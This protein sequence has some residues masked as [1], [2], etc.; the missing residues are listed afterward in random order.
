M[1]VGF[2]KSVGLLLTTEKNTIQDL[3]GKGY[4]WKSDPYWVSWGTKLDDTNLVYFLP[5]TYD[6]LVYLTRKRFDY[7]EAKLGDI[8]LYIVGFYNGEQPFGPFWHDSFS[9]H[10][11]DI[12]PR[13][14]RIMEFAKSLHHDVDASDANKIY[15]WIKS[16]QDSERYLTLTTIPSM[17]KK[18]WV[19]PTFINSSLTVSQ[20]IYKKIREMTKMDGTST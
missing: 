2:L 17:K 8:T 15:Q 16:Y 20:S 13:M 19:A 5:E 18:V 9:K 14:K 4:A 1:S 7:V 10:L 3:E 6:A 12:S 11:K